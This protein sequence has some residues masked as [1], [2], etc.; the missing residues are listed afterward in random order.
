MK[1]SVTTPSIP[2]YIIKG[3]ISSWKLPTKQF[4]HIIKPGLIE[5]VFVCLLFNYDLCISQNTFVHTVLHHHTGFMLFRN[6]KHETVFE[7]SNVLCQE[8]RFNI[9]LWLHW[10]IFWVFQVKYLKSQLFYCLCS[11]LLLCM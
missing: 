1:M 2:S 8:K 3:M 10:F 11:C 9:F 7:H 6:E 5:T 4:L